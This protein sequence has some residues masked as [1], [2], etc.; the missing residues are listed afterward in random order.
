MLNAF[1]QRSLDWFCHREIH[2]R[3]PQR[4]HVCIILIPFNTIG[5]SAIWN[6]TKV[7]S[8]CGLLNRIPGNLC[9]KSWFTLL[10]PP[11]NPIFWVFCIPND[12][13]RERGAGRGFLYTT[14]SWL[15]PNFTLI[16]ACPSSPIAPTKITPCLPH[17]PFGVKL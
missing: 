4:Q 2:I 13:V 14:T 16:D 9:R 5:W 15:Y 12:L 17:L 1:P 6:V 11:L 3:H 7:V 10:S 8:H